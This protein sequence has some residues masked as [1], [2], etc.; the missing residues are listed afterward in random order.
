MAQ[1]QF[2]H[3]ARPPEIPDGHPLQRHFKREIGGNGDP[4]TKVFRFAHRDTAQ[5][6]VEF[7][8]N[9][10]SEQVNVSTN[11]TADE[12]EHLARALLD[13]AHDLR[14]FSDDS[15]CPTVKQVAA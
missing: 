6:Q 10:F 15:I 14:S 13:A 9:Q 2:T 5:L 12:C 4:N 7:Y 3:T 8:A 11:L 1:Q